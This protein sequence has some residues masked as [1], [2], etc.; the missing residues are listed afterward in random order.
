MF[1]IAVWMLSLIQLPDLSLE[2]KLGDRRFAVREQTDRDL[3]KMWP[4]SRTTLKHASF[5]RD[6]E[7]WNRATV[8]LAKGRQRDLDSLGR[9]P[10]WDWIYANWKSGDGLDTTQYQ[11]HHQAYYWMY[12]KMRRLY[13]ESHLMDWE[14]VEQYNCCENEHEAYRQVSL[15][16]AT[17]AYDNGV[18]LPLLKLWFKVGRK[19]DEKYQKDKPCDG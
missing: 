1:E 13:G 8:L 3:Y 12:E 17:L 16:L 10:M 5:S 11:K 6:P 19:V 14:S 9:P 2:Q 18:P 4:L 7:V 15:Y